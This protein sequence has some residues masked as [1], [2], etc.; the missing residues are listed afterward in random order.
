MT[1]SFT[2]ISNL[3]SLLTCLVL[4]VGF[5]LDPTIG[6]IFFTVLFA[7]DCGMVLSGGFSSGK[8]AGLAMFT[9]FLSRTSSCFKVASCNW[10]QNFMKK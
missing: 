5:L 3:L 2:L 10:N 9:S 8:L 4:L 7:V 6:S 1:D